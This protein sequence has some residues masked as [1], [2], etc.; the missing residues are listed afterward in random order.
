MDQ[1][2]TNEMCQQKGKYLIAFFAKAPLPLPG[3]EPATFHMLKINKGANGCANGSTAW[4][5]G[6]NACANGFNGWA[7]RFANGWLTD[8]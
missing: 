4:A 8:G 1:I 3:L 5:N 7:N 2:L 6:L